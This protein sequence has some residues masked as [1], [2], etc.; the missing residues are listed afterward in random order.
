M[1]ETKPGDADSRARFFYG[2]FLCIEAVF[3]VVKSRFPG[4][5]S[6]RGR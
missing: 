4:F 6:R 3:S 2:D 5:V 1:N